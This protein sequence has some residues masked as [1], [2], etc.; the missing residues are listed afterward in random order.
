MLP[1][2][3]ALSAGILTFNTSSAADTE[4]FDEK[5]QAI[6]AT[7]DAKLEALP[8]GQTPD[9]AEQLKALD[10]LVAEETPTSI[11]HAASALGRKAIIQLF[12]LEETPAATETFR[13]L[14]KRFPETPAGKQAESML[15]ALDI[16]ADLAIGSPF[17]DFQ[18]KDLDGKPLSISNYQGK[19]ILIDFWATWCPPCRAELPN[20]IA[21]YEQFHDQGFEVIGISL[22]SK[23]A[24]LLKFIDQHEMPWPQTCDGEAWSSPLVKQYGVLSIPTTYLLDQEGNIIAKNLRGDDLAT[25]LS[26]LL[27]KD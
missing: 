1:L 23:Q 4:T 17:P 19:I 9:L 26:Q 6:M 14:L 7:V 12:Y 5:I 2:L 25:H 10:A 24:T 18:A 15:S 13:E 20:V 8:E 21:A 27:G 11:E 16:Q 3:A 22:D